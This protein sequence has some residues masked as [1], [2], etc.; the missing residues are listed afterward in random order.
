VWAEEWARLTP[1]DE[2]RMWDF[3]GLRI[4]ILRNVP[5]QGSVLEAGCGLG[6]Y[7]FYLRRLG[8]EAVG[9]DFEP[10]ALRRLHSWKKKN[11]VEGE[12]LTGDVTSLPIGDNS[13]AGYLSFGVVEHFIEG[14]HKA[15]RE[16]FRALRP[17]GIAIVTTPSVSFSQAFFRV[18]RAAKDAVKFV[19]RMPRKPLPFFQYWYR[20]GRLK[21]FLEG[22]GFVVARSEG[23]DLLYAAWEMGHRP[24]NRSLLTKILWHLEWT[25]LATFGNQSVVVAYK[26]DA[27]MHCHICG[28]RNVSGCVMKGVL[29]TCSRCAQQPGWNRNGGATRRPGFEVDPPAPQGAASCH[30]CGAKTAPDSLFEWSGFSVPACPSCLKRADIKSDLFRERIHVIWRPRS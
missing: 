14:P 2:I 8:I 23:A 1:E 27:L 6:R 25:P 24:S 30:Y 7:V 13:L 9:L 12:F 5:L 18:K 15:L 10:A 16:A 19:L 22:A 4:H 26:P 20:P 3:Y 28:E 29:P 11:G 21:K 17:G